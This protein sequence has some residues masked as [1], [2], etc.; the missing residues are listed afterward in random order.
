[1]SVEDLMS[2]RL[3]PQP[4]V[5]TAF[6]GQVERLKK[7]WLICKAEMTSVDQMLKRQIRR[8]HSSSIRSQKHSWEVK[9][10]WNGQALLAVTETSLDVWGPST[11]IRGA[12]TIWVRAACA[13]QTAASLSG[14]TRAA[15]E[16]PYTQAHLCPQLAGRK[17]PMQAS[18]TCHGT[19]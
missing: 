19:I 14:C 6:L 10:N 5:S 18:G 11:P 3:L 15:G 17:G 12:K 1:M 16:V 13:S 8:H 9:G 2:P 7:W 4:S